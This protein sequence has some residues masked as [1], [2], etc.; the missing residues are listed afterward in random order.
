MKDQGRDIAIELYGNTQ[1]ALNRSEQKP[2]VTSD[3]WIIKMHLSSHALYNFSAGMLFHQQGD[4][5]AWNDI[6]HDEEQYG[7]ADQDGNGDRNT[8][9]QKGQHCVEAFICM[10]KITPHEH[11]LRLT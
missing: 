8:L 7:H 4:W 2:E 10:A 11:Y 6:H 5:I 1:V 3:Q 9:N